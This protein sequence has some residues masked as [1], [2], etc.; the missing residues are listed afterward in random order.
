MAAEESVLA[1]IPAG[2]SFQEAASVPVSGLTAWQAL[3]P[4]MPL[5]GKRVLV[6]GGAGGVGSFAI[7]AG[8]AVAGWLAKGVTCL[9]MVKLCRELPNGP[10]PM[11]VWAVPLLVCP[12]CCLRTHTCNSL[13][14]PQCADCQG[15]GRARDHHVQR[16]QC[17]VCDAPAGR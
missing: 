12:H 3:A 14:A 11:N 2:V 7:Q 16:A 13:S 15:A 8:W 10:K 9:R 1:L 6:L 5:A 17:G 4:A